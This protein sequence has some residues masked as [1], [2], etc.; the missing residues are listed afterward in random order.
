MIT[1]P[2]TFSLTYTNNAPKTGKEPGNIGIESIKMPE[3]INI[4]PWASELRSTNI[5]IKSIFALSPE[6]YS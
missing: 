6:L 5:D 3:I 4:N 1:V 2:K